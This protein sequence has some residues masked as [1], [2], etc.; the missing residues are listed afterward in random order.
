VSLD[1]LFGVFFHLWAG[2]LTAASTVDE[3]LFVKTSF[4]FAFQAS[5]ALAV[6]TD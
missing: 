1:I 3:I 5:L 4:N 6:V 2:K